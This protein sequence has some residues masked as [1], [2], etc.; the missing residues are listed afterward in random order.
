M[1][2]EYIVRETWYAYSDKQD[3]VGELVRCKD[4]KF[5]EYDH[6]EETKFGK[7]IVAHEVCTRWGAS[8][9]GCVS[10]EHGYCF[11]GEKKEVDE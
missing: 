2:R 10:S 3:V 8:D 7:I 9:G 4:C 5:F 11:L 1:E 6:W